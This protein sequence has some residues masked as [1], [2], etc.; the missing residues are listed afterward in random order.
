M[1]N[2]HLSL[3][4]RYN[5]QKYLNENKS[6]KEIGRI[7]KKSTSTISREVY[8]RRIQYNNKC[9]NGRTHKCKFVQNCPYRGDKFCNQNCDKFEPFECIRLIK[10]PYVCNGCDKGNKCRASKYKYDPL[11]AYN[12]YKFHLSESR[13][14]PDIDNEELCIID[15]T[16]KKLLD[17]GQSIYQILTKHS[18]SV[19]E[20]TIYNYIELGYLPS[21]KNIDL[22]RKVKFKV[23]NKKNKRTR[24]TKIR[25]GRTYQDFLEYI[26][27]NPESIIVEMDTVIGQRDGIKKCLLTLTWRNST[28]L[29]SILL[30]DHTSDEVVKAI[31]QIYDKIGLNEF[32]R[33]FAVILTDNGNEFLKVDEIEKDINN[34]ER[35]RVFFCDP[36]ASWQKGMCENNHIY[37]RRIIPK[38]I[39]M[40]YLS[41]NQINKMNSHINS[42]PRKSL[43]GNTPNELAGLLLGIE[44]ITKFQIKNIKKD[45]VTLKPYLLKK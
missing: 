36:A 35:C 14:G 11:K 4:D 28:F 41:Q 39:S 15:Q 32:R 24:N 9:W 42:T 40:N 30:N 13:Q 29:Y 6:F 22:P 2:T 17:Q 27:N 23:R 44:I 19:N 18:F 45:K 10:A 20:R 38:G 26:S 16:F 34:I 8:K 31:N 1:K 12:D 43:N 37:I 3:D 7:L 25:K 5:I 21:V 33:I